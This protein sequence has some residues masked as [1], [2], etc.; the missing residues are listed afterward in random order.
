MQDYTYYVFDQERT[1]PHVDPGANITTFNLALLGVLSM[2]HGHL[3]PAVVPWADL[4]MQFISRCYT[5]LMQ[6]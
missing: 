2:L 6:T 5:V 4:L 3:P 1:A